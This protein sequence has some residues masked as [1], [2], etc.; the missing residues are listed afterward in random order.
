MLNRLPI[1]V[2]V[3]GHLMLGG[4]LGIVAGWQIATTVV[5]SSQAF[6]DMVV[7]TGAFASM[8]AVGCAI[9]GFLL[10]QV[11]RA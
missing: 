8:T 3:L 6:A 1:Q 10:L 4:L 5:R 2:L 9:S 11:E 7:V